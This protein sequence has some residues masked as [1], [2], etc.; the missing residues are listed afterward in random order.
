MHPPCEW[1]AEDNG[2]LPVEAESLELGP[3]LLALGRDLADA[4]LVG[5]DL[6]WL[7][8]LGLA[9]GSNQTP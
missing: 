3:A 9:P 7:L 2:A 1:P 5:D 4:D 8:A 6:N